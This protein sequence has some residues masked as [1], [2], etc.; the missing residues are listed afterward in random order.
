[1]S[2]T[3]C[4]ACSSSEFSLFDRNRPGP[5]KSKLNAALILDVVLL[6]RTIGPL[7]SQQLQNIGVFRVS[8]TQKSPLHPK[9]SQLDPHFADDWGPSSVDCKDPPHID[10]THDRETY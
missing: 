10:V 3:L 1:M 4:F 2:I 5:T 9:N 6:P 8:K 7:V